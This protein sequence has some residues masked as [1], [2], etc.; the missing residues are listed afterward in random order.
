VNATLSVALDP[1]HIVVVPLN[2]AVGIA[3]TP[4]AKQGDTLPQL[5]VNVTHTLP[6]TA[7]PDQFVMIDAVPC[8]LAIVTPLGTVHAYVTP[9]CAG[10]E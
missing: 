1:G 9:V 5:F 4:T 6:A 7:D 10:T 8:P 3:F 2:V